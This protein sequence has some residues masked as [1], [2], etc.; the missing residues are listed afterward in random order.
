MRPEWR[1]IFIGRKRETR[2][3]RSLATGNDRIS[4]ICYFE[5]DIVQACA[6][7]I[8]QVMSVLNFDFA[9]KV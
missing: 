9:K 2:I 8:A 5:W 3:L 1:N 7:D 6:R 4:Q